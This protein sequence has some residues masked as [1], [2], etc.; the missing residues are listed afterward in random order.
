[1]AGA[2]RAFPRGQKFDEEIAAWCMRNRHKEMCYGCRHAHPKLPLESIYQRE[3]REKNRDG[4]E[5]Y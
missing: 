2:C 3:R 1:M 5:T 4:D